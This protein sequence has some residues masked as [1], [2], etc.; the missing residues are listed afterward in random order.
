MKYFLIE[1]GEGN[2]IP[3]NVNKNL[4]IDI[5][6]LTKGACCGGGYRGLS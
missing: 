3:Y 4:A 2:R 5:R 1:T 6:F